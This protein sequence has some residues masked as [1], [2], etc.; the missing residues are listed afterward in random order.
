MLFNFGVYVYEKFHVWQMSSGKIMVMEYKHS[1]INT[2]EID[3][4]EAGFFFSK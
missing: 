4:S 1:A 2:Y 3:L